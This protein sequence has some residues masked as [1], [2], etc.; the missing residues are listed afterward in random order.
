MSLRTRINGFTAWVNLRLSATGHFMHNVLIDLLKGYNMKV[1]LESMTGRPFEKLQS[2]EGLTQQQK[3]TRVEWIVKE[4]KSTQ[5]IPKNTF[6]DSRM[7]AMR[8]A[9]QVFDLLWCL[10]CHDIWYVWERSE[11]LQKESGAILVSKPFSWT[12]PPP[13]PKTPTHKIEKDMLLGFGSRSLRRTPVDSP[14]PPPSPTITE[15]SDDMIK[16][17]RSKNFPSP[18]YCILDMVNA[19]LRMSREGRKLTRGIMSLDDLTDSRVLCALVN[20]F[21]PETF[22]TE[23]LLNDRWTINLALQTANEM[24]KSSNPFDSQDLV[25]GDVMSVCAYFAFFFMSGYK[26][27]QS[28]AMLKR[29][30]ELNVLKIGVKDEIEQFPE[31]V[32]NMKDLKRKKE[33]ENLIVDYEEEIEMIEQNYDVTKCAAWIKEVADI[34]NKVRIRNTTLLLKGNIRSP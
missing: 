17:R 27:R 3:T 31:F 26:F 2:F 34:Q 16:R 28:K 19:H 12:P 23:I 18:E 24:F 9:E 25:E 22:T 1:L 7:F 21:V 32:T 5:I 6:V 11:F 30:D 10:V 4:L 29:L 15:K 13:P 20:T 33:L 8:S 14:E